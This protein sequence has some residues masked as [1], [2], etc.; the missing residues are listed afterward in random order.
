ML[1]PKMMLCVMMLPLVAAG[2][3]DLQ[4]SQIVRNTIAS[5]VMQ[6]PPD[7]QTLLTTGLFHL[8]AEADHYAKQLE[9]TQKYINE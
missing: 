3:I 8:R 7:W 1:K 9:G 6:P 2:C 4:Y 5:G